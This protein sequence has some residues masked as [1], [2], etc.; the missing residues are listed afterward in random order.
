MLE[1]RHHVPTRSLEGQGYRGGA[2][3]AAIDGDR[4]MSRAGSMGYGFAVAYDQWDRY[5]PK[6]A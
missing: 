1:E 4:W 6:K 2:A 5:R 3:G